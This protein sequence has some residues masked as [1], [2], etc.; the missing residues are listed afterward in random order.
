MNQMTKDPTRPTSKTLL[1]LMFTNKPEQ[2]TRTYN[3][4]TGL[5]DDDLTLIVKKLT[6]KY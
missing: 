5:P 3:L 2:V 1:D 4:L 6:K